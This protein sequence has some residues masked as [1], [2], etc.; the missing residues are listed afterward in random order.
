MHSPRGPLERPENERMPVLEIP[1]WE[2]HAAARC[3]VLRHRQIVLRFGC[4]RL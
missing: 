3:F 1:R 2:C 4:A